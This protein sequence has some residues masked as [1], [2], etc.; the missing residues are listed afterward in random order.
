MVWRGISRGCGLLMGFLVLT[1]ASTP[2]RAQAPNKSQYTLFR[3]TPDAI[4]R[5]MTTDRPDTTEVPFTVDAGHF[6]IETNV[7]GFARSFRSPIGEVTNTYD[8][9]TS[10][11][12]IGLTN[13]I[14]LSLV[15]R[16]YGSI[17]TRGPLGVMR[18]SGTGG[19]DIR[20]KF[21]LWGNDKFEAPGSTG[22]ALLPYV[23]LPTDRFNGVSNDKI[24]GGVSAI[25]AIKFNDTFNLG[26][27]ASVAA[28]RL[29]DIPAYR[30][31][32][33]L[34]FSLGHAITEKFGFY[35]EA[36]TRYG[37]NDGLGEIF[38]LGG[39]ITYKVTKNLQLDAGVNFGVTHA[40]DRVNPFLGFSARF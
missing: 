11:V 9:M 40:S 16:P 6:Q 22:F 8:V 29:G 13:D 26:I 19:F 27:N 1:G 33:I 18:Q 3:P 36:I 32:G 31:G 24:E 39:G 35:Y 23:T 28:E 25:W 20:T 37:L 38:T 4:M 12:R 21:N 15:G 30:P 14:E 10:N 7:F 2:V 5:D 34:T 17:R